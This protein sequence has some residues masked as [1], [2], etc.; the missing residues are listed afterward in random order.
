[1]QDRQQGSLSQN[2]IIDLTKTNALT[3]AGVLRTADKSL[4]LNMFY[5]VIT[6]LF[7]MQ[8]IFFFAFTDFH[9]STLCAVTE[10][11][12]GLTRVIRQEVC[13]TWPSPVCL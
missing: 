4:Q 8:H 10:L 2:R 9:P 3:A 11:L 5:V 13:K 1:M 7:F 12:P 6:Q